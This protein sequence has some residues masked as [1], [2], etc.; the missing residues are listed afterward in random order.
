M[1][2]QLA[3]LNGLECF[4]EMKERGA[5]QRSGII[6]KDACQD[7]VICP[8]PRRMAVAPCAA[9]EIY[10]SCRRSPSQSTARCEGEPGYEILDIFLS[11]SGY[12]DQGIVNSSLPYFCGSPPSRTDNPLV[13]DVQFISKGIP[14]SSLVSQK[15]SCGSSFGANPCIRVE[16]FASSSSDSHCGVLTLA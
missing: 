12:G 15:S 1:Q 7:Q 10:R 3:V 8:K 6:G 5:R 13:Q 2:Q 9:K 14:P 16:G 4:S 11:K